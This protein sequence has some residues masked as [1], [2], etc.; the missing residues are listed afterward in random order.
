MLKLIDGTELT[1]EVKEA[2]KKGVTKAYIKL[3]DGTEI[4][5]DNYL[6]SLELEDIRYNEDTGNFIGEAVA[7]RVTLDIYNEDN[8]IDL[9]DKEFEV[10]IGAKLLD[11]SIAWI[12]YGNFIVQKPENNDTKE[13]SEIE[14]FDYMCKFNKIY[15]PN[16]V[17]PCTYAELAA[18]VCEQ[19]GVQ[20][21]HNN[22]RNAEN[23]VLDNFFIN[24]EQC[25]VVIKQIAKIAFSWARIGTDNKLYFDFQNKSISDIS[26]EFTLDGYIDLSKNNE[27]IPINTIVL[28]NSNIE[29]EN[30]TIVDEDLIK[31][32]GK[33][34]ELVI[35]EDYF[36]FDEATRRILIQAGRELFGLSYVP[37]EVSGIGTAYLENND[38][39]AIIDK[40][41]NTRYSYCLNHRIKYNGTLYDSIESPAMTETETQYQNESKDDLSRRR[42]EILVDKANQKIE[43]VVSDL[44]E[45]GYGS[46]SELAQDVNSIKTNIGFIAD[47]TQTKSGINPITLEEC[48]AGELQYLSIKANNTIFNPLYPSPNL[49]PSPILYPRGTTYLYIINQKIDE[50]DVII[51]KIQKIDLQL[52]QGIRMYSAEI[53]DEIIY[54]AN[55]EEGKPKCKIIRRVG[56][57]SDDTLYELETPYEEPIYIDDITL[58][59]G[60][61]IITF[62]EGHLGNVTATYV[63]KNEF[64]SIFATTYEVNSYITQL[65]NE[66]DLMVKEKVGKDEV[67]ADLNIA[68]KNGQ[69]I[70]EFIANTISWKSDNSELTPDGKI[71][72]K[73]GEVAGLI[74]EQNDIGDS[75]LYKNFQSPT[76]QQQS[77]LYIPKNTNG[78]SIFLYAG[79]SEG[80]E[81]VYAK[82][83]FQHNGNLYFRSGYLSMMYAPIKNTD[84]SYR[85]N[86]AMSFLSNG[87][88][89]YLENGNNWSYEGISYV[90]GI[91][92]GYG[93]WL[94]DAQEYIIKDGVHEQLLARFIRT[95]NNNEPSEVW[96]YGGCWID[97]NRSGTGY[98]I[99]TAGN[100][101]E[102]I[103]ASDKNLKEDI[104]DSTIDALKQIEAINHKSF[105]WNE[106]AKKYDRIGDVKL[107]YIAQELEEI[108][109][110]LVVK[111]PI[112]ETYSI[113]HLALLARA[114]KA[115]QQLSNENKEL[116]EENKRI[117]NELSNLQE[118]LLKLEEKI[119]GIVND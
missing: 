118:R 16:V 6:Q 34:K 17:Y 21:G 4:N 2:F 105:T 99:V 20:L 49:Y 62:N 51:E 106:K 14:A 53:Y 102:I 31:E 29:G 66:I 75:W 111:S 78:N 55:V 50:N 5:A 77:G 18:D 61:N 86:N 26:E 33:Q 25:R 52:S 27:I 93:L 109:E 87:T 39:I 48:L 80:Q 36:A 12:S 54:D 110:E 35:K 60:T 65:A 89:R 82:S 7:R 72:L 108:D 58:E 69:G 91:E 116:R 84:G 119:G 8:A 74:M 107:G 43:A 70:I 63:K 9:E 57:L 46:F 96:F 76:G 83:F 40:Q 100:Y 11:N 30:V 59:A 94:Y 117:N 3:P 112:D 79:V 45:A 67:I 68:I 10:F 38:L 95:G 28:R 114:T 81:L 37:I 24:D 64:T 56:V 23:I 42:T 115:I 97:E 47:L 19:C 73:A 101:N 13:R 113:N 104:K 44:N 98:R 1:E 32:Y 41:G 15:K 88:W 90:D 22:F 103:N 92:N 71:Y 85:W